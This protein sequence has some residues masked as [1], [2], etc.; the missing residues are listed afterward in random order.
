MLVPGAD[1][2]RG[3]F[4]VDPTE[5]GIGLVVHPTRRAVGSVARMKFGHARYWGDFAMHA[6]RS[7]VLRRVGLLTRR[8]L[9]HSGYLLL[10]LFP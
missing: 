10:V 8:C 5:A 2:I 1:A 7:V 6:S 4:C 9:M 3:G